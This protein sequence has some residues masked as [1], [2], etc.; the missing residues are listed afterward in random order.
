MDKLNP[1]RVGSAMAVTAGTL[2]L[3]CAAAV[4]LFPEQTVAF[5]NSWTHG[6]DLTALRSNKPI[7]LESLGYGLFNVTL[8][9]YLIG[10]LFA[11]CYNLVARCPFCR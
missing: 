7:T 6:L 3:V 5:V 1:W 8:T 2:S 9:G 4:M 10:V 11:G